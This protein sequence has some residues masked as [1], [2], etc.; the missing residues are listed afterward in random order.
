MNILVSIPTFRLDGQPSFLLKNLNGWKTQNI[1]ND[2]F[3]DVV[4][5]DNLSTDHFYNFLVDFC[6]KNN[7]SNIKFHVLSLTDEHISGFQAFNLGIHALKKNKHY[8]YIVYSADDVIMTKPDDL[9]TVLQCFNKDSS[10]VSARMDRD[11]CNW[12]FNG[13]YDAYFESPMVVK[14]GEGPNGHF[15][16]F[17]SFFIEKYNFKY[18]D[19]IIAWGNESN[20]SFLCEAIDQKWLVC[21]KVLFHNGFVK[22]EKPH[23]KSENRG[24]KIHKNERSFDNIFIPGASVGLGF[25]TWRGYAQYSP[26]MKRK[27]KAGDL[28]PWYPYDSNAYDENGKCKNKEAM[29]NYIL[30]N[31]YSK[32]INY[33]Q[34]LSRSKAYIGA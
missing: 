32:N 24:F 26:K 33:E 19:I 25:M 11:N 2:N 8:D 22:E 1:G 18:P 30:E 23:Y 21:C 16:V 27:E 15:L 20:L 6:K 5:V 12:N 34:L 10:I 29:Y 13:L 3:I 17:S 31:L 14:L 7:S 4:L 9:S 28:G